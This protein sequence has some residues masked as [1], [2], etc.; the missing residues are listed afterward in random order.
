[1]ADNLAPKRCQGPRN[2]S[3]TV[4]PNDSKKAGFAALVFDH[5]YWKASDGLPRHHTS[6]YEQTQDTHDIIYYASRRPGVD[7][8]RIALC[9]SS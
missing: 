5:R 2:I 7:P 6:H 4:L 3:L 9:G 8:T 1:M